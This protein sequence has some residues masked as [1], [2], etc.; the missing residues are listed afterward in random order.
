M[1]KLTEKAISYYGRTDTN[2]R[3]ALLLKIKSSS[4]DIIKSI[5]T[6]ITMNNLSLCSEA[7]FCL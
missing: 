7:F 4:A 3:K 5:Y 1:P 2:N 6:F